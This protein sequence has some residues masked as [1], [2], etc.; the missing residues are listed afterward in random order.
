M[1]EW[2][3]RFRRE[4]GMNA[5]ERVQRTVG[6]LV[7]A[8]VSWDCAYGVAERRVEDL[9]TGQDPGGMIRY[10]P[11]RPVSFA[12]CPVFT[13]WV[14]AFFSQPRGFYFYFSLL[15]ETN[16]TV[17]RGSCKESTAVASEWTVR[18]K[19]EAERRRVL[20]SAAAAVFGDRRMS[21]RG[22]R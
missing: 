20:V 13:E 17:G 14:L 22:D 7:V 19:L 6:A 18:Y 21:G 16:Y 4:K 9:R 3:G 1:G 2:V 12:C 10:E 15:F 8:P 11:L 5:S